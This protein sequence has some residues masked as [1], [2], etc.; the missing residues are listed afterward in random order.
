VRDLPK[1]HKEVD[2]S[3]LE[4]FT[5]EFCKKGFWIDLD[6][7]H[8]MH[9]TPHCAEFEVLEPLQYMREN[10]TIKQERNPQA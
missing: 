5:C 2:T 4:Q 6:E 7:G 1:F 9:E 10:R 3:K 8:L